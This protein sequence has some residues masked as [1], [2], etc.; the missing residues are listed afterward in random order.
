MSLS[1]RT[2]QQR[3]DATL[4]PLLCKFKCETPYTL[5]SFLPH[6]F[7]DYAELS[8]VEKDTYCISLY[9]HVVCAHVFFY[10]T[11]FHILA[12]RV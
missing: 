7:D 2:R 9:V 8:A 5:L 11:N 12:Q 10:L 6:I 3:Y 1:S 4:L